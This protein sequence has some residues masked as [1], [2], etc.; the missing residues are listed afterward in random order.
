[1]KE[2]YSGIFLIEEKGRVKP[3]VNVYVIAGDDGLIYDAGYGNKRAIKQF[4]RDFHKL[5]EIFKQQNLKFNISR[6][7]VSHRH[8]DHFSGLK[9]ISN[10]LDI[11]I[12]L[13]KKIADVIRD[14]T[15]FNRSFQVNDYEDNLKIRRNSVRK[16][17]NFLRNTGE[18]MVYKRVF[19]LSYL[20]KP[21]EII[22]E[23]SEIVI[24]REIWKIFSS[25]GHSPDHISLYNKEKGI[26]FSGDNVL[27]L[28]STWLGP[29]ESNIADYIETIRYYQ[30]L[31][32]LKLILPAHGDI[33]E[34]PQ[35]TL[36]A[37]LLRMKEREEQVLD[38]INTHSEKG[39]S[40][41]DI[42]KIVYPKRRSITRMI[43]RG[44]VV[45]TLKMLE[46]KQIIERKTI[47]R[48]ILFFPVKNQ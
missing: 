46:T 13:T 36:I 27:N 7:V 40:P 32:N 1:M 28:R 44:W 10:E 30:N 15:S 20:K 6:I 37:I 3:S 23:D 14:K 47:K 19:G 39:I 35:E 41:K 22:S 33:I 8:S 45:L 29:P 2:V 43:G 11:K 31:P 26:L 34:N 12:V 24:N 17:R 25:P 38:A 16:I 5:E 9:S 48:E 4:L 42:V 21:D 18:R